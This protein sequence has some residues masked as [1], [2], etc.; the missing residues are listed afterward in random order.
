ASHV[1]LNPFDLHLRLCGPLPRALQKEFRLVHRSDV[2][3]ALGKDNRVA[4]RAAAKIQNLTAL[5][6]GKFENLVHLL[7]GN[8]EPVRRKQNGVEVTPKTLIFEPFH[9]VS[10]SPRS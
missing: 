2:E 7:I 6:M 10:L 8:G 3:S 1:G 5:K 4:S 9:R